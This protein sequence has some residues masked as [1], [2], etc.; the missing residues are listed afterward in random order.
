[1]PVGK[2]SLQDSL[3]R[4]LK[5]VVLTPHQTAEADEIISSATSCS[6]WRYL[7]LNAGLSVQKQK[8]I[9]ASSSRCVTSRTGARSVKVPVCR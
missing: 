8:S 6:A 4:V 7:P 2:S 3:K 9:P 5:G 1:M